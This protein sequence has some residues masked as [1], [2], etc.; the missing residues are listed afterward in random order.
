MTAAFEEKLKLVE[1]GS[2]GLDDFVKEYEAFISEE[3]AKVRSGGMRREYG[4]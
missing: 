3:L 2:F 4:Q 1:A